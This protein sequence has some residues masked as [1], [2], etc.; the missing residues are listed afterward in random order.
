MQ[1]RS[2]KYRPNTIQ[3]EA[4]QGCNRRCSFCGTAGMEKVIHKADITTIFHTCEL[5]KAA[6]LNSRILLAGHGEPTLHPEIVKI[7]RTIR[8]ILPNNMIHM[9]TNGTVIAK[10]PELTEELFR[11]G[12]NDLI[13]DEYTDSRIGRFVR[14]DPICQRYEVVELKPGVPLF[15][16]KK[17][18]RRRICITPPIDIDKKNAARKLVNHCG[19]GSPPLTEP[20]NQVCSTIFRDFFIRWDGNIAICCDDFRGEYPVTNI[21]RCRTFEEAWFHERLEAARKFLM[22]KDRGALHPCCIC[23][24]KP[25][26][27]GLLP[28]ATGQLTM[29]TPKQKDRE[30]VTRKYDPL[31]VIEK[32]AWE[33]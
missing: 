12:L 19:A 9:F 31:A 8:T 25:I 1:A 21:L 32:R 4:V 14:A 24:T 16:D 2:W 33:K 18:K 15:A 17:V 13:F 10:K 27:A 3:I 22:A 6:E 11:A 30:I 20:Y 29:P 5:I 28:D 23:N 7:V 26:R